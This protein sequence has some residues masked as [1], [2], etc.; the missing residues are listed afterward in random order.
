ME[1]DKLSLKEYM[2]EHKLISRWVILLSAMTGAF[3]GAIIMFI[4]VM[5]GLVG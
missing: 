2:T 5:F 4:F 3:A 1:T